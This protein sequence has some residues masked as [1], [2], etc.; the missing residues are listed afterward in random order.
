MTLSHI[1]QGK[2]SRRST[3]TSRDSESRGSHPDIQQG[4]TLAQMALRLKLLPFWKAEQK[5]SINLQ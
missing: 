5:L 2:R 1:L 3:K 4:N